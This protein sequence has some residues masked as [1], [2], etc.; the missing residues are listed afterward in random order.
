[1]LI[2]TQHNAEQDRQRCKHNC[3]LR[4]PQEDTGKLKAYTKSNRVG[5]IRKKKKNADKNT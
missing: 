1:M 4:S 5:A 3:N 2:I